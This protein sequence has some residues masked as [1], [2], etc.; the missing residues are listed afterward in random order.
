ML[1]RWVAALAP[2]VDGGRALADVRALSAHH[3]IQSTPGYDDAARELAR[4]AEAAG[5]DVAVEHVAADGIATARGCVLPE[6]WACDA[7]TAWLHGAGGREPLSDFAAA[8]LSFVQR[9]APAAGRWP[10]VAVRGGDAAA[11]YSGGDVR[12]RVVLTEGAAGPTHRLAV[13]ERGAVGLACFG[14]RLLPPVRTREHDL[15]SLAYT[16]FWWAGD[17]P[18]GWGVVLS[19]RRGEELLARLA[20]GEPLEIEVRLV[21]RRFPARIPLVTAVIPG[22]LD[23]EVLVTGH[24]CHP[25]PGANDNASGA[26]AT[27]EAMRALAAAARASELG[28]PRRTIRALWMPEFTGTYA[29]LAGPGTRATRTLAALNLDMVGE[30]QRACGSVQLLERAPHFLAHFADDLLSECRTLA[31]RW[32]HPGDPPAVDD[33]PYLGG[34]DHAVWTDPA[35]GVPCPMLIQWPD[36]FY[37]SSYDTPE[38]CDP[39]S[40]AHAA[41]SAAAYS[42]FL[43]FAGAAEASFLAGRIERSTVRSLRLALDA[44][45]P[46]RAVRAARLRGQ[47]ALGSLGRFAIGRSPAEGAGPAIERAVAGAAEAVEG[48]CDA[49]IGPA[50]ARRAPAAP[51]AP[52]ARVPKRQGEAMLVAMRTLQSAGVA[53][54]RG[55]LARWELMERDMPGGSTALDLA[56]FACDGARDVAEIAELVRDE[57]PAVDR[58]SLQPFFDLLAEAGMVVWLDRGRS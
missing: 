50:L 44:A 3:R 22:E 2:R 49:E 41:L 52:E 9:S 53:L 55:F 5:L 23:G 17:E 40:L 56:W 16:S 30:D 32:T 48:A 10:L 4:R 54:G 18:R 19:P 24:L 26:A 28:T 14:R 25:K 31:S 51:R 33:S 20:A 46:V 29:W 38:R 11:A 13:V 43:A 12:G 1:E 57:G 27:L 39:R 6:G 34:S 7:G 37:H 42:G 47:R 8:P 15:D 58:D 45:D 35:A 21:T 36:R